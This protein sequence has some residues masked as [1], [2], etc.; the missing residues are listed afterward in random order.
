MGGWTDRYIGILDVNTANASSDKVIVGVWSCLRSKELKR[1]WPE[2]TYNCK[3]TF[4]VLIEIELW[5]VCG[6]TSTA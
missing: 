6:S 5:C 2:L 4:T 3:M 1:F